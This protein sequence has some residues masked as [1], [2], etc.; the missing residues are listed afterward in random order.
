MLTKTISDSKLI[1][2][3]ILLLGIVFTQYWFDIQ[4]KS[5]SPAP[6]LIIPAQAIKIVDLGLDSFLSALM[7]IYT[8]Q[9][10]AENPS[11]IPRLIKTV[12]DLDPK[13]GYPYAFSA[14]VLP[15]LNLSPGKAVEIAL[16][17]IKE[18]DQDWRIPYYLAA[19]YHIYFKDRK[20]AALYFE[21]AATTPGAPEGIRIVAA[22]YGV[23]STFR[24]QTKELWTS[25]YES[26]DDEVIKEQ[27]KNYIFHIEIIEVL[28]KAVSIYKQKYG[29]NPDKLENLVDKKIL[30]TLPVSPLEVEFYINKEGEILIR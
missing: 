20:N 11:E 19:A 15:S 24:S 14:L 23:K 22:R 12:N 26:S 3:A 30:K 25:I 27:A 4:K 6:P 13:F 7:W 10:I 5:R 29:I 1:I 21:K 8:I 18:V 16:R 17:G 2:A 28:E 9:Q